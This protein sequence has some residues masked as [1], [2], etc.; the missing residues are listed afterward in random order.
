MDQ[1]PS[2][3]PPIQRYNEAVDGMSQAYLRAIPLMA[4]SHHCSLLPPCLGTAC[5]LATSLFYPFFPLEFKT[6]LPHSSP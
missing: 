6:L 1:I 2:L 5:P 4:N 3:A